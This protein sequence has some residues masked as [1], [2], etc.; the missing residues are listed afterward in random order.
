MPPS[1]KA[2]N[3]K[4]ESPITPQRTPGVINP[5]EMYSLEEVFQRTGLGGDSLRKAERA[6]MRMLP[7]GRCKFV[8]GSDLIN[9][10]VSNA[11]QTPKE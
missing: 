2:H 1:R 8:L 11:S 7:F 3:R 4:K 9:Q 5:N 10:A 6:G